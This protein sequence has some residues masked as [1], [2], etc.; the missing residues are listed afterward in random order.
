[1]FVQASTDTKSRGSACI[2]ARVGGD[3]KEPVQLAQSSPDT[4]ALGFLAR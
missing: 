2:H 4:S 1:M 3:D